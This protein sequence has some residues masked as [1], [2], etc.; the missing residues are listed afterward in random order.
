M[1]VGLGYDSIIEHEPNYSSKMKLTL[2]KGGMMETKIKTQCRYTDKCID[3]GQPKCATCV[4][5]E[6][7]SYY[8]YYDPY[9]YQ[10]YYP[11]SYEPDPYYPVTTPGVASSGNVGVSSYYLST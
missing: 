2:H 7:R 1:D 4:Y 8:K 9:P 5:N 3:E 11:W 6:K 10:P